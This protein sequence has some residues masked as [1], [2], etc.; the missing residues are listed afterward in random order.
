MVMLMVMATMISTMMILM[1]RQKIR[2]TLIMITMGMMMVV[3]IMVNTLAVRRRTMTGMNRR[4]THDSADKKD[5]TD[6]NNDDEIVRSRT[7]TNVHIS[8][9]VMIF[10]CGGGT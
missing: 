9:S 6:S 5:K 10:I 4:I 3:T 1:V 2:T 7:R 8:S